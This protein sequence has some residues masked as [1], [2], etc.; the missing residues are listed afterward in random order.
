TFQV[1]NSPIA[2][3]QEQPPSTTQFGQ[4]LETELQKPFLPRLEPAV[5]P[6][7]LI[8]VVEPF[9]PLEPVAAPRDA[10]PGAPGQAPAAPAPPLIEPV[11]GEGGELKGGKGQSSQTPP[12]GPSRSLV[13]LI[14]VA[15][16]AAGSYQFGMRESRRFSTRWLPRRAA[17][18]RSPRPRMP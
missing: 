12:E 8:D 7:A 18:D 1:V 2:A 5:T 4:S 3:S 11:D 9:Q 15:S 14:G 16:L 17:A 13:A 6:H 10:V